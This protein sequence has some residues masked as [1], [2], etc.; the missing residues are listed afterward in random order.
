MSNP[1]IKKHG[2][3]K[4]KSGNP[5]G[6]PRVPEH[7]KGTKLVDTQAVRYTI[8][9]LLALTKDELGRLIMDPNT[10][11]LELTIASIIASSIKKG[12]YH[13]FN[14][15]L[16]R[17]IGKVTDKIEHSTAKPTLIAFSNGDQLLLGKGNE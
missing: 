14:G 12:D 10:K 3:K 4:G 1:N 13:N 8:S 16:D 15:L 5:G 6:R 17:L 9:N 11:T 2:F 7:L